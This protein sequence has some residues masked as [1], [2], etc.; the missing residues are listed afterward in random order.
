LATQVWDLVLERS[1]EEPTVAVALF[2][3]ADL[4]ESHVGA[5]ATNGVHWGARLALTTFLLHFPGL[6]LELVLL[7]LGYNSDL[8][9]DELKAFWTR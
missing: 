9:N 3:T 1:K 4:I 8:T 5:E 7:G 2:E 6:E